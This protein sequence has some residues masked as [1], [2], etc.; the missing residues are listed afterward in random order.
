M[1]ASLATALV[2][3]PDALPE[4]AV[5]A[6]ALAQARARVAL[7]HAVLLF[8]TSEFARTA[9][10]ALSAVTR[11]ARCLNV[12]GCTAPGVL[13]E[14]EW[15]I[16]GP[17]A[18]ALVMGDDI[19]LAAAFDDGTPQLSLC[20]PS[21]ATPDW[22]DSG[23][24]RF[25]LIATDAGAQ[26]AGRIFAHGKTQTEGHCSA[27]FVGAQALVGIARG[28]RPLSAPETVSQSEGFEIQRVGRHPA[29][30]AL[31]HAL[32]AEL[33]EEARLPLKQLF[34]AELMSDDADAIARGRFRVLPLIGLNHDDR[35]VTLAQSV[36]VGTRVFW[37]MRSADCA[38]EDMQHMV[39]ALDKEA[40]GTPAFGLLFSCMGR[41][42][43]FYG[44]EDRDLAAVRSRFPGMP[45]IGAYGAGQIAP[46]FEGNRVIQ[47]AAVLALLK[48]D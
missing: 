14:N 6:V 26:Q 9:H 36:E 48:A 11:S 4:L 13:T 43:Y 19:T 35:S 44:G 32:P 34:L 22:L 33:H 23:S 28:L 12:W 10:L 39:D 40:A 27:R 1:S 29:L 42:P 2:R 45:L 21:A 37:G 46:L 24:P 7:P 41:G 47:N 25:G 31:L 30:N 5:H 38:E 20:V 17:A 16:E 8:L 3:G 18:C 15:A